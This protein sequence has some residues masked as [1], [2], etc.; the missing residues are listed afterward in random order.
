M[1]QVGAVPLTPS[2]GSDRAMRTRLLISL[3]FLL[4]VGVAVRAGAAAWT[5]WINAPVDRPEFGPKGTPTLRPPAAGAPPGQPTVTPQ[6]PPPTF[7][8]ATGPTSQMA[9]PT[10]VLTPGVTTVGADQTSTPAPVPTLDPGTSMAGSTP[11]PGEQRRVAN[12]DGLGVALRTTPGGDRQPGKGYDEGTTLT[13]L[14]TR[15]EWARIR[16]DDGREGWVLGVTLAP[17]ASG[18][19]ASATSVRPG[20]TPTQ[21]TAKPTATAGATGRPVAAAGTST[22]AARPTQMDGDYRVANTDGLGVALRTAP[23]GD[24]LPGKGYDEGA[25]VTVIERS[26]DWARIRGP[27]GREGWV[28][29]ATLVLP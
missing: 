15:G 26:G 7:A 11:Q 3:A 16:G 10:P 23:N 28:P 14:E 1:R 9:S 8:A 29:A 13:V 27:D 12:T 21:A 24:R 20:Q 5:D 2:V 6:A 4:A 17:L 19:S 22:P 25:T 18:S